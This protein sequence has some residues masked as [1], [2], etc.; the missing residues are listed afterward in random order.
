M[1]VWSLGCIL[2]ELFSRRAVLVSFSQ[3]GQLLKIIDLCGPISSDVWPSVAK[4]PLFSS[5]DLPTVG[6]RNVS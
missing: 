2:A 5:L 6:E 3:Q 1:D 4:L